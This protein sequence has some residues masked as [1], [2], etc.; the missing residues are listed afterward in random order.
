MAG[1]RALENALNNESRKPACLMVSHLQVGCRAR[2]LEAHI[3][4]CVPELQ[5]LQD[6]FE[7]RVSSSLLGK[8]YRYIQVFSFLEVCSIMGMFVCVMFEKKRA[9]AD[10][11]TLRTEKT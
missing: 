10:L 9:F 8:D 1:Y 4:A 6:L 11:R 5:C 3:S 7:Y 2:T